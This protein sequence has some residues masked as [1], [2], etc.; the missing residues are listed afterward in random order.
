MQLEIYT[1]Q[2]APIIDVNKQNHPGLYLPKYQP[3]PAHI[4]QHFL[5]LPAAARAPEPPQ[6]PANESGGEGVFMG[7]GNAGEGRGG[8]GS[9]SG[10]STPADSD[11]EDAPAQ[12][13]APV[14]VTK[15]E[16]RQKLAELLQAFDGVLPGLPQQCRCGDGITHTCVHFEG[17]EVL[18]FCCEIKFERSALPSPAGRFSSHANLLVMLACTKTLPHLLATIQASRLQIASLSLSPLPPCTQLRQF[19]ANI[20][21]FS[22]EG[23]GPGQLSDNLMKAFFAALRSIGAGLKGDGGT[24]R[25]QRVRDVAKKLKSHTKLLLAGPIGL[26]ALACVRAGLPPNIYATLQLLL[27]VCGLLWCKVLPKCAIRT[28]QALVLKAVCMV[29]LHLPV[30]ERDIKLHMLFELSHSISLLGPCFTYSMFPAES[31]WGELV[32]ML[33]NRRY[34]EASMML[35]MIDK[36]ILSFFE[37]HG[38]HVEPSEVSDQ[39]QL[40]EPWGEEQL[41]S[42]AGDL[43]IKLLEE[44]KGPSRMHV[45]SPQMRYHLRV[46]YTREDQEY[47]D[48][49]QRYTAYCIPRLSDDLRSRLDINPNSAGGWDMN[50]DVFES[51]RARWNEWAHSA[52][53]QLDDSQRSLTKMWQGKVLCSKKVSVL[54]VPFSVGDWFMARPNDEEDGGDVTPLPGAAEGMP[55]Y[56]VPKRMWCGKIKRI[57]QHDRWLRLEQP[58]ERE[59]M[60]EVEWHVSLPVEHGGP[61]SVAY[62]SPLVL[63]AAHTTECPFFPVRS[64]L[65]IKF[66]AMRSLGLPAR[67][68]PCLVLIRRQ[69]HCLSAVKLPVPWP[70]V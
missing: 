14:G 9:D 62:Q 56:G 20:G 17:L 61:Y 34:A 31:R 4:G 47:D 15:V 59:A 2:E 52:D 45:L 24:S 38:M 12:Q 3:D 26:Y 10:T 55:K 30:S 70:S 69:W 68:P 48:L 46:Y 40:D 66:C 39:V 29:E 36:E 25:L 64:M 58:D 43:S 21:R 63:A 13:H 60:L 32:R 53:A 50:P 1:Q 57:I 8:Q 23:P 27:Q 51:L 42:W 37:K 5:G 49:W 6:G 35:G 22:I 28:L 11:A 19:E 65:P 16:A 54:G 67:C 41:L 18:S 44:V 7:L 33:K